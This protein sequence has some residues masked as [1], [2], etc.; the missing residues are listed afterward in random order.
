MKTIKFSPLFFLKKTINQR[1]SFIRLLSTFATLLIV[2]SSP[3]YAD[4]SF[5]HWINEFKKTAL[6]NNIS[7]STFDMAFKTIHTI[8]QEVLKKAAYQPEF[9]D[10]PWEYFDNRIHDDAIVEGKQQAKKWQ[11]WLQKIEKRF[12]VNRNLL[13]AIWSMESNYGKILTNKGIMR[14]TIRSLATLAYADPKRQKYARTQLIAAMKIL[15]R[16][17]IHRSQLVGS[18]AGAL[19]HTQFIPS[20]YLIYAIDMDGSG[21]SDIWNSIPDSLATSANL[22][23]TNGWQSNLVWGIEVKL[24][25]NEKLPENWLSFK[26]WKE[27]GVQHAHGKPFPS[28]SEQ[29][30]L[31]FP[32]GPKGPAFLVTKNFFVLK[33]YNNADRYAFAVGLL[34]DRI[35]GHP[36][37][38]QDWN[39]PFKPITFKERIELQSRLAKLGDY[40]GEI[41]GKIGI[42]SKKAIKAFQ[43]RHGLEGNGYPSYETL[44]HIRK[45]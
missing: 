30:I 44:S 29:A 36:K 45:Q 25:N 11:Q 23:Y 32:D 33:R 43:L 3:T 37:L 41:D 7:P 19:G 18:W 35:A 1:L 2:F 27:L 6:A 40:E 24:P 22:L 10:M 28:L 15:Q 42:A 5:Q 26:Q 16:G 39:R 9:V 31:K 38:F 12:G 4:S 13:L 17:E 34:S 8:D 14:D 20:S 21:R